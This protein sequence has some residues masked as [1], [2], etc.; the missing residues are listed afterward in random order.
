MMRLEGWHVL[1]ILGLLVAVIVA[2]AVIL[3]VG[4]VMRTV[5]RRNDDEDPGTFRR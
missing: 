3:V 4:L 2:I 1:V 5:A